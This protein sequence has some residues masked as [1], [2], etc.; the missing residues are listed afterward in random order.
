MDII[1]EYCKPKT[2]GALPIC[3][4]RTKTY[5]SSLAHF[6]ELFTVAQSDFPDLRREDCE[7]VHY[8]GQRYRGTYGIEFRWS[9]EIPE[10]YQKIEYLEYRL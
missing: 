1:R 8:A 9:G 10:N 7:A 4:V 6:D 2:I 3:V 5:A